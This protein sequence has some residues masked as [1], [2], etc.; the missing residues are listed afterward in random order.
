MGEL[1]EY[2]V[3]VNGHT[4]VMNLCE[5]DAARLDG[6]PVD[7][8]NDPGESVTPPDKAREVRNKATS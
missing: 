3:V 4:T 6:V 7:A 5:T 8:E 2:T 1:R